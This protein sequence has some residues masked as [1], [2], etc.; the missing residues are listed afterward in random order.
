[1]DIVNPGCVNVIYQAFKPTLAANVEAFPTPPLE[2]SLAALQGEPL[3]ISPLDPIPNAPTIE[4]S[5]QLSPPNPSQIDVTSVRNFE[6]EP[7][8]AEQ[9]YTIATVVDAATLGAP[10][11]SSDGLLITFASG[12]SL[13]EYGLDLTTKLLYFLTGA[14][15]VAGAIRPITA[16]GSYRNG[17]NVVALGPLSL[18]VPNKDVDGNPFNWPTGPTMGDTVQFD[19]ARTVA[20]SVYGP[21]GGP[22]TVVPSTIPID[23]ENG[24]VT[25]LSTKYVVVMNQNPPAGLVP[26]IIIT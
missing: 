25:A 3:V 16:F 1:M 24:V 8:K 13:L 23:I 10:S 2:P 7:N 14:V 9:V 11:T 22:T 21:E 18:I 26:T 17:S 15:G 5:D 20:A 4:V 6:T 19:T 12:A